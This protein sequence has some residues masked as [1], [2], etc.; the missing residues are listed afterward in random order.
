M[1]RPSGWLCRSYAGR[2]PGGARLQIAAFQ[3]ARPARKPRLA[4]VDAAGIGFRRSMP[5]FVA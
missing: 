2:T 1:V 5:G 4:G 3:A